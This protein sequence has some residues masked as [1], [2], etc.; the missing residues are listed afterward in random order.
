MDL[1][2]PGE[3][4][5]C[6]MPFDM[7]NPEQYAIGNGTSYATPLTAGAVA[8]IKSLIPEASKE[9]IISKIIET[10]EIIE[11]MPPS[12]VMETRT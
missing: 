11:P 8:L 4:I 6:T 1:S 9:T 10:T 7:V 3:A 2:A 5:I 12:D